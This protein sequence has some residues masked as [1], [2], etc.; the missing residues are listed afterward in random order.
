MR[1]AALTCSLCSEKRPV[2]V[3]LFRYCPECG[4]E[5]PRPLSDDGGKKPEARPGIVVSEMPSFVA[6]KSTVGP[7]TTPPPAAVVDPRP[8]DRHRVS[9]AAG[10]AVAALVAAA[11]LWKG[12][13]LDLSGT[14][15]R[16]EVVARRGEWTPVRLADAVGKGRAF[17]VAGDGPIRVRVGDGRPMIVD[18][19]PLS[20]G[21][22]ADGSLEIRAVDR[23]TRVTFLAR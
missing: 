4:V 22:L 23:E 13:L 19:P 5:L 3:R 9:V 18:G 2:V 8:V 10:L 14:D 11:A 15:R 17:T 7:A 6:A 20:L 12:G 1:D 16:L 21:D